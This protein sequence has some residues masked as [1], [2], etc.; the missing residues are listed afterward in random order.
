MFQLNLLETIFSTKRQYIICT[1]NIKIN[2]IWWT[3]LDKVQPLH[4]GETCPSFSSFGRDPGDHPKCRL[5]RHHCYSRDRVQV[6]E[7]R[8]WNQES[9]FYLSYM[10]PLAPLHWLPVNRLFCFFTLQGCLN[11]VYRCQAHHSRYF[12]I[13][14]LFFF[15]LAT[16]KCLYFRTKRP[17]FKWFTQEKEE[18]LWQTKLYGPHTPPRVHCVTWMWTRRLSC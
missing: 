1:F 14:E 5:R 11:S 10:A 17:N 15:L 9:W 18:A 2:N 4:K 16:P 3:D 7:H 6:E 13:G 12:I 8:L